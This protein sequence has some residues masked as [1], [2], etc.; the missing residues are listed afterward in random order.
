MPNIYKQLMQDIDDIEDSKL[1]G[2][3][4]IR[5]KTKT[6]S[7]MPRNPK[8]HFDAEEPIDIKEDTETRFKGIYYKA[9]IQFKAR[10][11]GKK[12]GKT[13]NQ[14]KLKG[15]KSVM[16]KAQ[17]VKSTC[18]E[19]AAL[20][21]V[22]ESLRDTPPPAKLMKAMLKK[23]GAKVASSW[24]NKC[25]VDVMFIHP[26]LSWDNETGKEKGTFAQLDTLTFEEAKDDDE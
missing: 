3:C 10:K 15:N 13:A 4:Y 1:D 25:P 6:T 14:E 24:K 26:D 20:V 9:N 23:S 18:G 12:S 17:H 11:V 21:Y 19:T 7:L 8:F 22:H 16:K 5:G 2:G